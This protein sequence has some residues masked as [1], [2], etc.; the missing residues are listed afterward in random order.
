MIL[1][2]VLS[3]EGLGPGEKE[4][5]VVGG[6]SHSQRCNYAQP[7]TPCFQ[8]LMVTKGGEALTSSKVREQHREDCA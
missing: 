7:S 3:S 8:G 4:H 6:M 1:D 2:P 5:V